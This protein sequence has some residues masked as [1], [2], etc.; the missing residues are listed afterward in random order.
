MQW[1]KLSMT[2]AALTLIF[3]DVS[4]QAPGDGNAKDGE[5]TRASGSNKPPSAGEDDK[6]GAERPKTGPHL[7]NPHSRAPSRG[8]GGAGAAA[9]GG[10]G[11]GTG[12]HNPRPWHGGDW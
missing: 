7:G 6:E 11:A 12:G 8:V 2:V 1:A 9:K 10:S 3:C 4:A 5:E